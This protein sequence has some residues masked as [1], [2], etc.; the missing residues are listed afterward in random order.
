MDEQQ[1]QNSPA[2]EPQSPPEQTAQPEQ[3][4]EQKPKNSSAGKLWGIVLLIVVIA[5]VVWLVI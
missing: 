1:P 3:P 5:L 4:M 2:Q